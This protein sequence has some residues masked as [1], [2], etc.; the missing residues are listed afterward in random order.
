MKLTL[1]L[2]LY[3]ISCALPPPSPSKDVS[4]VQNVGQIK[5]VDQDNKTYAIYTK[6]GKSYL[7]LNLDEKF[8]QDGLRVVFEGTV[9]TSRLQNVRLAGF[10]IRIDK[11][12]EQ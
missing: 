9:D 10:P 6:D 5:L 12:R 2:I 1:F 11:I 4:K 7:P 3:L 8:K